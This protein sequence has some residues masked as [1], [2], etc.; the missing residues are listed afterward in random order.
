MFGGCLRVCG[1]VCSVKISLFVY[2]KEIHQN[3]LRQK[4][5]EIWADGLDKQGLVKY[6]REEVWWFFELLS[7][8]HSYTFNP[9]SDPPPGATITKSCQTFKN[10]H[11][12]RCVETLGE[13]HTQTEEIPISFKK[14]KCSHWYIQSRGKHVVFAVYVMCVMSDY[15]LSDRSCPTG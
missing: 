1:C 12:S 8:Q 2:Y 14:K 5:M 15:K 11:R 6:G 3:K 4:N 13:V 10:S 9:N 7:F